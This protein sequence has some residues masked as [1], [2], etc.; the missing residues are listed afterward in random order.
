MS[1]EQQ[2]SRD[3]FSLVEVIVAIVVLSFGLLAMAASTGYVYNQLRSTAFDTQRNLAR[4]A[5]VEQVRGMFWDSIPST[6]RT[7][8]RGRYT[9]TYRATI[10]NSM[11]KT[12]RIITTGPAYRSGKAVRQTVSDTASIRVMKPL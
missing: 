1:L 4:Q 5:T 7:V 9:I 8:V 11:V 10:S 3:G 12:V 2:K 6:A